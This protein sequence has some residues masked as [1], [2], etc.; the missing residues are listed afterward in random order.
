MLWLV[1]DFARV[2]LVARDNRRARRVWMAALRFVAAHVGSTLGLWIA[3]AGLVVVALFAY[4]GVCRL[5]PD[6]T[7]PVI[8]TT[9]ALQQGFVIWRAVMRV[10][11]VAGQIDQAVG[12]GLPGVEVMR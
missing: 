1:L 12:L 8:A 2:G 7:W 6:A 5:L 11:L 9:I 10:T 3:V 4:A